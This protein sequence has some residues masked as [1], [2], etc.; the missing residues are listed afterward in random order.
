MESTDT[1]IFKEIADQIVKVDF[2]NDRFEFFKKHSDT[3]EDTEE[4]KLEYTPIH[5]AYIYILEK[6]IEENLS[7]KFN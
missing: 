6:M 2:T 4:N 7:Q 5:E 1:Q 3:F